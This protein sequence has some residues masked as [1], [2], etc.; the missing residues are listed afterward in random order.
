MN[1]VINHF[2]QGYLNYNYITLPLELFELIGLLKN[3]LK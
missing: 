2:L 1:N 3:V